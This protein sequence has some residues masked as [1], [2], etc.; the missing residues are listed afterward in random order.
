MSKQLTIE[1]IEILKTDPELY[2]D[3]TKALDISPLYMP[4]L[5]RENSRRLTEA[6]STQLIAARLGKTTDE[7]VEEV[8]DEKVEQ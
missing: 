4:R 6:S 5:I 3:V 2:G 7:V 8:I 1:A